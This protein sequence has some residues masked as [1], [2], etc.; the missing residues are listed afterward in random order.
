VKDR[1]VAA[2]GAAAF[3]RLAEILSMTEKEAARMVWIDS[4]ASDGLREIDEP[5]LRR[6]SH[7]LAVWLDLLSI[8][9]SE[10]DAIRWLTTAN[11]AFAGRR[12]LDRMS[13]AGEL[14]FLEVRANIERALYPPIEG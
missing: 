2:A 10:S 11:Q 6:I 9:A 5:A 8:F 7:V 14:G 13:D 4:A 3:G 1:G 12:P